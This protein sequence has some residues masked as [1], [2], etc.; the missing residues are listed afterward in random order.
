[1]SEEWLSRLNYIFGLEV[2]FPREA[3]QDT[4]VVCMCGHR[5][6]DT[7]C[8]FNVYKGINGTESIKWFK[9]FDVQI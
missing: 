7:Y 6:Q 9:C 5:K 4:Q 8:Q 1:M 2:T 3:E